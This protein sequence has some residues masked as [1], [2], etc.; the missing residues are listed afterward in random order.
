MAPLATATGEE[1]SK[2]MQQKNAI[3][4]YMN[5]C[6]VVSHMKTLDAAGY[7]QSTQQ[8]QDAPGKSTH[9]PFERH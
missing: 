5:G 3:R 8:C 7:P 2:A 9:R 6:N 4:L 1:G